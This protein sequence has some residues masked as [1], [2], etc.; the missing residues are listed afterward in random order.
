[1][2]VRQKILA[3]V[4]AG[5]EGTR[6][7]PLTA[8]RCKPAV[9]FGARYRIVDFALSNLVNSGIHAI[10][11]LVQYKSQSLIEHVRKSWVLPSIPPGNFITV[12]PPQMRTGQEW[13]RGTADAVFQNLNLIKMHK[14]D[15]VAVFGADHIYRM[16]VRQMVHFHMQHEAEVTVAAVPVTLGQASSFGIIDANGEGVIRGFLEKPQHPPAMPGRPDL[17]YASM[18]NY[19]FSAK[20]LSD[21]VY[22]CREEGGSD[23]GHHVI[24]RLVERGR[25]YAYDFSANRVPG[26]QAY[27]E[28]A[29]WR[30]V[31]TLDSYYQANMELL[32]QEPRFD[33]FNAHWPI[34][35]SNYQGPVSHFIS[36]EI[37]NSLIGASCVLDRAKVRSSL[38]RREVVMEA[39]V[40]VEDCIIMDNVQIG[41][42]ARLRRVIVD[43][44]NTIPAGARI[45]FDPEEDR[46]H[47]HVTDSGLVVLPEILPPPRESPVYGSR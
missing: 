1:M 35:S 19:L 4:M 34:F 32:G 39:G 37:E 43:R 7:Q 21:A 22:R 36:A 45:G 8:E 20:A 11:L 46:R 2:S 14:P 47:F 16:N 12:V 40:E 10:Y 6:L 38:I 27:E 3:M 9:P 44:F 24:P 31:G 18:G 23:F 29:Y 5:G 13:F 42:G 26:V 28:A 17:A 30:D 41:R 15:L 33:L 25:V